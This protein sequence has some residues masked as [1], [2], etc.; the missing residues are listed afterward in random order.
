M[1]AM[2]YRIPD[3]GVNWPAVD[4]TKKDLNYLH[5]SGPGKFTLE[6]SNNLGEKNLW[7]SID[8]NENKIK[9]STS[10]KKEEL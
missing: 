4:P 7:D 5:I 6:H 9:E 10:L 8:F 2:N 3:F 1:L